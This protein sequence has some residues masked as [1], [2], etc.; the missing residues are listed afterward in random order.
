MDGHGMRRRSTLDGTNQPL[1]T[2]LSGWMTLA[3]CLPNLSGLRLKQATSFP[4][5]SLTRMAALREQR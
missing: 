4:S 3:D 2:A 5:S 1:N